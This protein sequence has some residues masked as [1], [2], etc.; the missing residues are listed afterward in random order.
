MERLAT[1]APLE[2]KA[3]SKLKVLVACRG[4]IAEEALRI[5]AGLDM[6]SPDI[7]ISRREWL[8]NLENQAPWLSDRSRYNKIHLLTDYSDVDA[9]IKTAQ[10][11]SIDAIYVGYGFL[12]ENVDFARRC[13]KLGIRF[14]GPTS[15]VLDMLGLKDKARDICTSLG[16]SVTPGTDC[17]EKVILEQRSQ[18]SQSEKPSLTTTLQK[19][20]QS[21]GIETELSVDSFD[22]ALASAYLA[23]QEKDIELFS[24]EE[25]NEAARLAI[26]ELWEKHGKMPIRI[27]ASAGGGGKGQRVIEETSQFSKALRE[28]WSEIGASKVGANKSVLLEANILEPRHIEVQILGDG[29]EVVH[30]AVRDCSFQTPFYQ[31]LIEIALHQG[32]LDEKISVTK[33]ESLR[34]EWEAEKKLIGHLQDAAIKIGKTIGYRGAGTVEFLVDPNRN[35][36]FLEVNPRI[37]VEHGV[38]EEISRLRGKR[39]SL[40][41]EQ[42]RLAGVGEK[43]GY[44][45]EDISFSGYSLE[46]RISLL[47]SSRIQP[48]PGAVIEEFFFASEEGIRIEDSGIARTLIKQKREIAPPPFYDAN[49]SLNIYTDK[50]WDNL[51]DKAYKNLYQAKISGK[52]LLTTIPFHLAILSWL[53]Q[54]KPL[55]RIT[56]SFVEIYICLLH[57]LQ[58]NMKKGFSKVIEKMNQ[59][60]K[61]NPLLCQTLLSDLSNLFKKEPSLAM[62]FL[63]EL[64]P[65]QKKFSHLEILAL[66]LDRLSFSLF[67]EDKDHFE[68]GIAFYRSLRNICQSIE[69]DSNEFI[70]A[71]EKE[72]G[73]PLDQVAKEIALGKG[74]S[75]PQVTEALKAK[76]KEFQITH[77]A[78][79]QLQNDFAPILE[80][81]SCQKSN[82]VTVPESVRL[83]FD[84]KKI[85]AK[86]SKVEK[87]VDSSNVVSPILGMFYLSSK[88]GSPAFVKVGDKV[89]IGK[90][91]C[92]VGAMKV[93]TEVQATHEGIV[94][95][96]LV[97]DESLVQPGQILIAME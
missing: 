35:F 47:D 97:K 70:T 29:E 80:L 14:I 54:N 46:T 27:K 43:L 48:A 82:S 62:A 38:S 57:N 11:H 73:T 34:Q 90:T 40:I 49:I 50:S 8:D 81:S 18:D 69:V 55:P 89:T 71:L 56:T 32:Q 61:H 7:L 95:E 2:K 6:P 67:S 77:E 94:K 85:L 58:E 10:E 3:L 64:A 76:W 91:L 96:I 16:I 41:A 24:E 23:A 51:L 83:P 33:D 15:Y 79:T 68:K 4:P 84:R 26:E 86:I 93:Y 31:K 63:L 30:F 65:A 22:E 36:Y 25:L 28:V 74:K 87:S 17:L 12:A 72:S 5:I 59:E 44:K 88:P 52:S 9:I 20:L 13:E 53:R 21:K 19:H 42:I 60:N 37:Q 1:T 39:V 45:Q 75:V 66:L 92:L 78:L